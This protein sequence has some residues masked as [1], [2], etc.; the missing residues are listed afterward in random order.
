MTRMG[1]EVDL[2]V[3]RAR[4]GEPGAFDRLVELTYGDAYTLAYRLTGNE[5]D[6]ADVVQEAYLRVYR[7]LDGFRGDARFT[8]W[9]Y[10]VT[11]NCASSHLGRRHRHRHEQLKDDEPLVDGCQD[12]DPEQR[13][14]SAVL[15]A[16]LEKA[17][18]QLSPGLRAVV[19]LRDVYELPH[20]DIAKELGI[21]VT[22]AKVRLHRARGQLR[23]LVAASDHAGERREPSLASK[24]VSRSPDQEYGEELRDAM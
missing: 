24:I 10:R 18:A 6:A 8:T 15:R 16:T 23:D 4:T 9:L 1:D 20:V 11:A 12:H 22:A 14:D 19:V 13:V 17:I 2:I 7:S 21:S 5:H 3:A